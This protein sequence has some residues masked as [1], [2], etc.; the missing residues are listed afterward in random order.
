VSYIRATDDETLQP[1]ADGPDPISQAASKVAGIVVGKV[2]PGYDWVASMLSGFIDGYDSPEAG[3]YAM[4][5]KAIG[6][7]LN[8]A[9]FQAGVVVVGIGAQIASNLGTLGKIIV[10]ILKGLLDVIDAALGGVISGAVAGMSAAADVLST[11]AP[12]VQIVAFVFDVIA[13]EIDK[14][15][16]KKRS[17]AKKRRE[18]VASIAASYVPVQPSGPGGTVMPRDFFIADPSGTWTFDGGSQPKRPS[19]YK[20]FLKVERAPNVPSKERATMQRLRMSLQYDLYNDGDAGLWPMYL[21]MLA[22]QFR[23]GRFRYPTSRELA[24]ASVGWFPSDMSVA[25]DERWA[26]VYLQAIAH[27]KNKQKTVA[28]AVKKFGSKPSY[29]NDVFLD[30][31]LDD[32]GDDPFLYGFGTDPAGAL[33]A[34]EAVFPGVFKTANGPAAWQLQKIV[35]AWIAKRPVSIPSKAVL[36]ATATSIVQTAVA[37]AKAKPA[38]FKAKSVAFLSKARAS[39]PATLT[40]K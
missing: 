6:A 28:A 3:L 37:F 39:L 22:K 19:I 27:I 29:A 7:A 4:S 13:T 23:L 16:L 10:D 26:W 17:L 20:E 14:T 40:V 30:R 38:L 2:T 12:A 8:V 34:Y 9:E 5:M 31:N 21:D 11:I 35:D 32:V 24:A 25:N 1:F 15:T 36:L 18:F 33:N